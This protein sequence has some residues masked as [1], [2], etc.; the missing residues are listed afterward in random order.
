MK[1]KNNFRCRVDVRDEIVSKKVSLIYVIPGT[2]TFVALS[3]FV[4]LNA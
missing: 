3:L 1:V 4:V 2:Y